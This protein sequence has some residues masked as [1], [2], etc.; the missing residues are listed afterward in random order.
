M[1]QFVVGTGGA[2][3]TGGLDSRIPES[4]V[5]QN[6][7]FGVL[8]LTLHPTS[9][10][11]RF[12]P[13]AGKTFTDS[14]T[15]ACHGLIPP[16]QPPPDVTPPTISKVK[17]TPK[18]FRVAPRRDAEPSISGLT[19]SRTRF[20]V[21]SRRAARGGTT[22]RYDLSEAG[23]VSMTLRRR[24]A[25]RKVDGKCRRRTHANHRRPACI[26]YRWAGRLLQAS[27]AGRNRRRFGGRLGKR[28]L[29]PGRFRA[30]FVAVD[31]AA[32]RSRRKTVHFTIVRRHAPASR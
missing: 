26:R 8:F 18:R 1:R 25:G 14:G 2:F 10:D 17:I 5:A 15:T 29:H 28:T 22:F 19:L 13:E 20:A 27:V 31:A 21:V 4:E 7:T 30:E 6:T 24:M 12:V 3:F 11:W 16:P 32:N 9:Y 23:T